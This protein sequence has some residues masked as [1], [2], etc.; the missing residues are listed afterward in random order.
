MGGL[1]LNPAVSE[2]CDV[3]KL[4]ACF[5]RSVLHL[6]SGLDNRTYPQLL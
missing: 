4:T 2:L 1:D 5:C 3:A 6:K